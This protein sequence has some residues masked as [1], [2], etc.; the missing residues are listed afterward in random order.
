MS[1]G[2]DA[3]EKSCSASSSLIER[4]N[5]CRWRD[6]WRK[7]KVRRALQI[8][9]SE[10]TIYLLDFAKSSGENH[11]MLAN[12]NGFDSA[13]VRELT[14][15]ALQIDPS[16]NTIYLLH[17]VKSSGENHR[18]LT[19]FNGFNSAIVCTLVRRTLIDDIDLRNGSLKWKI[20]TMFCELY[21]S[22]NITYVLVIKHRYL[23]DKGSDLYDYGSFRI[24][25]LHGSKGPY[26]RRNISPPLVLGGPFA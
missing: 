20:E 12:F 6:Q 10:N 24:P 18:L 8:D 5:H 13:I 11:C 17:F 25:K 3:V 1:W 4:N 22:V 23:P 21:A 15:S 16:K 2:E 26:L 19:T 14:I 7:E 9:A